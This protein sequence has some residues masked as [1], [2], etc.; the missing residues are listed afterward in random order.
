[1]YFQGINSNFFSEFPLHVSLGQD[2]EWTQKFVVVVLEWDIVD[3]DGPVIRH[4]ANFVANWI[5]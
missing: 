4:R 3:V 5:I 2:D 1:M